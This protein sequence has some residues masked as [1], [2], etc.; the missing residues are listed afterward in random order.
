MKMET[1]AAPD[2]R[3]RDHA[4]V[5][6]AKDPETQLQVQDTQDAQ[7]SRDREDRERPG[8]QQGLLKLLITLKELKEKQPESS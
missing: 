2:C 3:T 8:A 5:Q 4:H 6:A 1:Q 7:D